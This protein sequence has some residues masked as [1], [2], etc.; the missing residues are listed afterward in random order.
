MNFERFFA[1]RF[2]LKKLI[3]KKGKIQNLNKLFFSGLLTLAMPVWETWTSKEPQ[4]TAYQL[5]AS[6]PCLNT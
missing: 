6:S 4:I 5:S 1:F 2:I 3:D